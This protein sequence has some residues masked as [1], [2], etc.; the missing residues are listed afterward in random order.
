MVRMQMGIR[1]RQNIGD[2]CPWL[3]PQ[4]L[5]PKKQIR[6]SD[7]AQESNGRLKAIEIH[8]KARS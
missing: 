6:Y 3:H 5:I 2:L 4:V 1:S 7:E 8:A